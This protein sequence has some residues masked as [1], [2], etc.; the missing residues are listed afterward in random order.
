MARQFVAVVP[1]GLAQNPELKK[2]M[3][4]LKRT[5]DQRGQEARWVPSGLWHITLHFL[6]DTQNPEKLRQVLDEWQPQVDAV[7]LRLHGLGAFP[8]MDE[9][10][11]LWMGVQESQEFLSLQAD[12]GERL[13]VAGFALSEREFKPHLTLARF[14]NI[15]NATDLVQLGGR[16]HFGDYAIGELILFESVLQGNILKYMPQYRKSLNGSDS[17]QKE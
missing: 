12:L 8:S 17:A 14:R 16:K 7:Q 6:G 9:A 5:M 11:I 3:G 1:T 15:I 4:K 10:R 2:L 13:K